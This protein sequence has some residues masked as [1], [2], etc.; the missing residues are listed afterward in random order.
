MQNLSYRVVILSTM[1]FVHSLER[2]RRN[3]DGL[4]RDMSPHSDT[5][6]GILNG[7]PATSPDRMYSKVKFVTMAWHE[8]SST[9][10]IG[11][12]FCVYDQ[13]RNAKRGYPRSLESSALIGLQSC[14]YLAIKLWARDFYRVIVEEGAV[15]AILTSLLPKPA[16]ISKLELF[17]L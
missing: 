4:Q 11:F 14:F 10:S 6:A 5:L 1:L 9:S 2:S 3:F 8:I 16:L 15:Q 17:I 7:S 13:S 12:V